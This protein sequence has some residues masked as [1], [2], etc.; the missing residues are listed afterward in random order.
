M[1]SAICHV[2]IPCRDM[3]RAKKFYHDVFGWDF[4]DFVESYALFNTGSGVGGGLDLRAEAT[5]GGRGVTLY[6]EVEDIPKRLEDVEKAGGKVVTG[7]TEISK[8]YGYSALFTD[9]EGN[10]VGLWSKS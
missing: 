3:A 5:G 1:G 2:E 6:L 4:E 9:T 10:E 8:E 7:K